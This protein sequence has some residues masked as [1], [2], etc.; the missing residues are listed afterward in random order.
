MVGEGDKKTFV[1]KCGY[2]EKLTAFEKRKNESVKSG[3]K[4]DF[5]NYQKEQE[6]REKELKEK[7]NPFAALINLKLNDK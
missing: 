5:I 1:C 4:K 7:S 3:G 6:K 2:K